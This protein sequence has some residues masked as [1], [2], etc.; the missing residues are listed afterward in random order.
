MPLPLSC[1]RRQRWQRWQRRRRS[2]KRTPWSKDSGTQQDHQ[3]TIKSRLCEPCKRLDESDDAASTS[4]RIPIPHVSAEE[5]WPTLVLLPPTESSPEEPPRV[6]VFV[7]MW[8]EWVV[9]YSQSFWREVGE[10]EGGGGRRR[11]RRWVGWFGREDEEERRRH[12]TARHGTA[13][14]GTARHGT[15]R[16]GTARHGSHETTRVASRGIGRLFRFRELKVSHSP[17]CIVHIAP[18]M[19]SFGP[20]HH[21]TKVA[22]HVLHMPHTQHAHNTPKYTHTHKH[23]CNIQT[24][25]TDMTHNTHTPPTL[26]TT[27]H[28]FRFSTITQND[29]TITTGTAT[30]P[31]HLKHPASITTHQK[32]INKD[33]CRKQISPISATFWR[34]SHLD[35][36][37]RSSRRQMQ[38]SRFPSRPRL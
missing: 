7:K 15:A 16:H 38:T 32:N 35:S 1:I 22:R 34:H 19:R 10:G 12:G 30:P 17:M 23:T 3:S 21:T 26:H 13:R 27:H 14:H 4:P 6:S 29:H 9:K 33:R 18:N 24:T 11:G 37:E 25:H 20:V 28:T 36:V 2:G 5:P 8:L 31:S